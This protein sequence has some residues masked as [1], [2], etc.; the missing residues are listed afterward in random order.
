MAEEAGYKR[1]CA[2]IREKLKRLMRSYKQVKDNDNL[3]GRGRKSLSF[4]MEVDEKMGDRPI[5]KPPIF[6]DNSDADVKS[7]CGNSFTDVEES[8]SKYEGKNIVKE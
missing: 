2:Q 6:M 3:S 4:A 7:D 5:T 1:A 8:K